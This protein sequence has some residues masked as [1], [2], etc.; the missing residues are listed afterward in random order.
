M[1]KRVKHIW[2]NLRLCC[3]VIWHPSCHCFEILMRI[4]SK[5]IVEL[6]KMRLCYGVLNL[7]LSKSQTLNPDL[8]YNLLP[9][10]SLFLS[11]HIF[12][13]VFGILLSKP[14]D[15]V[16]QNFV[17]FQSRRVRNA[18]KITI[19]RESRF[20]QLLTFNPSPP[21][22]TEWVSSH[23]EFRPPF[24]WKRKCIL[25]SISDLSKPASIAFY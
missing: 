19:F 13:R 14:P 16:V 15:I 4:N 7:M 6:T 11:K 17:L 12:F 5:I 9:Q 18:H 23:D 25:S 2:C 1:R 8:W 20:Y 21:R 10:M 22:E 3:V 24:G